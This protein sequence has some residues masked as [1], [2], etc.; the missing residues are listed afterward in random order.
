[1]KKIILFIYS[2]FLLFGNPAQAQT[3]QLWGMT[4]SGGLNDG[5]V[6][7]HID[8]L[9]S[10]H[11][12]F[13]YSFGTPTGEFPRGSLL[14]AKDSIFYGMTLLDGA[15]S[16]G[17]LFSY[18]ARTGN[19]T[20]L[21][22]FKD[23][24]NIGS[25]PYGSLIQ[26]TVSG[27]LYGMTSAGGAHN[28]GV[29]FSYTPSTKQY[30]DLHDFDSINGD[31]PYGKLF[32]GK[33]GLVYGMTSLGGVNNDGVIF[34]FSTKGHGFNTLYNFIDSTGSM[35]TGTLTLV[36]NKF[37][38][39]ASQGGANDDGVIFSLDTLT[40]T[41]TDLL[42]FNYAN[43]SNPYGSLVLVGDSILYGM[44]ENGIDSISGG[45][46]FRF[47]PDSNTYEVLYVF[48]STFGSNPAGSLIQGQTGLLY[49]TTQL[50]GYYTDGVI[51]SFDPDSI[52]Y[53]DLYDLNNAVG[54]N[55]WGD[56]TEASVV[57]SIAPAPVKNSFI[58]YPNPSKEQVTIL[59]PAIIDEIRVT[60][61]LG[62][63]IYT[64]TPKQNNLTLSLSEQGM[65]FV[66]L[67]SNGQIATR[68]L[69]IVK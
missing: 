30:T 18:D 50:G 51:F 38:G 59:S 43:G 14:Y 66:T 24:A 46:I 60:D 25:Y 53:K 22:D 29:I 42:D 62:Q 63:I 19:Y 6:I 10:S 47:N 44:T 7:M 8:E 40:N 26:D 36:K 9:D 20:D 35:P 2:L 65:Y 16:S 69:I 27:L 13:P 45:V 67:I 3:L 1:M 64:S 57:T 11:Y 61:L 48:D 12:A 15:D 41:Y 39:M 56:L 5:G 58:I 55:P 68:K 17:V 49:G 32:L 23:T 37:Y 52:I 28:F 34:S 33:N 21:I 31:A 54:G 4:Y